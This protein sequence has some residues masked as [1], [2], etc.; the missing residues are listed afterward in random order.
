MCKYSF[1]SVERNDLEPNALPALANF[2]GIKTAGRNRQLVY[3]SLDERRLP[4]AGTA[5]Q[6]YF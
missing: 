4:A 5:S 3:D 2:L 6:Q 1:F